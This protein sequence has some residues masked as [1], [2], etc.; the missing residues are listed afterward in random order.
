M[1][2]KGVLL[3]MGFV[4]VKIGFKP[5]SMLDFGT[6]NIFITVAKISR[7][8]IE[9]ILALIG[10]LSILIDT[11]SSTELS[12]FNHYGETEEILYVLEQLQN[13]KE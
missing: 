7:E 4:Q 11:A 8:T 3:F 2:D 12:I 5:V 1:I 10:N 9:I 13:T 6:K